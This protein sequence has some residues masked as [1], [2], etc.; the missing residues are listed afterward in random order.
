MPGRAH[1]ESRE[2]LARKHTTVASADVRKQSAFIEI[3][4]VTADRAHQRRCLIEGT[5]W[6]L[7]LGAC[8][9]KGTWTSEAP[10]HRSTRGPQRREIHHIVD[11]HS[12]CSGAPH[13]LDTRAFPEDLL[14]RLGLQRLLSIGLFRTKARDPLR[15]PPPPKP[16]TKATHPDL[17]DFFE[18]P[19]TTALKRVGA[20]NSTL[21]NELS[22]QISNAARYGLLSLEDRDELSDS[23]LLDGPS[24]SLA[25]ELDA[26]LGPALANPKVRMGNLV[27]RLTQGALTPSARRSAERELRLLERL[28]ERTS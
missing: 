24:Q 19:P 18:V 16:T 25:F 15:T 5:F 21:A 11:W 26:R 22:L 3:A 12:Q 4:G 17:R 6:S 2:R 27:E 28:L 7:T 1:S 23:L 20:S 9:T 14:M 13:G 10:L 8:P